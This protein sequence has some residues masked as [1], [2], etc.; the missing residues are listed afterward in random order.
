MIRSLRTGISGLKVNQVRMDVIGNNIANVNTAAFKRS[1]V[2]FNELLGSRLLGLGRTAGGSGINPA[3]IGNGVA[4]GAVDQDWGQGSFEYTNLGTDLALAGDGF[5]IAK[6]AEGNILTRAGNFTFNADGQLTSA[7]GLAIQG[8][9]YNPDGTLNTGQLQDIRLDLDVNSAPVETANV[10]ISGNLSAD[11]DPASAENTVTVSTVTYDGE[12]KAHTLVL[13]L[14]KTNTDEWLV[15]NAEIA[16][17]P[18]ATP[19]VA[20]TPLQVNG[21]APAV[22]QFDTDGTLVG[23]DPAEFAITGV[24]PNTNADDVAVTLD[25]G[26]LTQYGGSTTAAVSDQDGQAA[27]RVVGYGI[28][29]SGTLSLNFSNGE[30]RSIA[31]LAIGMVNNPNGLEQLGENFYG[32]TGASGDLT[33]GRAGQEISTAVISGALE[34]SNVDLANEFTDM[35]VTQRGYQ[36]SARVITTSDE[37]L[38]EVVQLKR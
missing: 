22:V 17:D 25:L 2:A 3:S 27:G 8:W 5:F 9:S 26:N 15:Q 20:P 29:P 28:D 37:I 19:P 35:I 21:G 16:G 23:P 38:Q 10:T 6:G 24:F 4:V 18:E 31:Q 36:A 34:A 12:G 1:R 7:G 33:I 13:T 11:V 30:Q 14:E 32:V